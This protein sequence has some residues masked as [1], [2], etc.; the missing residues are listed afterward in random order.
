MWRYFS[1]PQPEE[2]ASGVE[3]QLTILFLAAQK[4]V[5]MSDL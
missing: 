3:Q 1:V 2:T 4:S 5:E